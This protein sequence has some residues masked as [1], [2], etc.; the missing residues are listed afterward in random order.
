MEFRV[1][2]QENNIKVTLLEGERETASAIC[3]YENTPKE[4]GKMVGC[5]GEFQAETKEAGV[6]LL[7]KC[8]EI[9][10]GKKADIIVVRLA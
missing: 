10:E 5:I 3:Y 7:D 9:L 4:D 6:K 1:E 2:D 8:Q